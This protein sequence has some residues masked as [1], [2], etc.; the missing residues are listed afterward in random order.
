M[1]RPVGASS[2]TAHTPTADFLVEQPTEVGPGLPLYPHAV[3]FLPGASDEPI[4]Q[5]PHAHLQTTTYYTDDTRGL[6]ESW[7]LQHLSPE[8]VRYKDGDPQVPEE[9]NEMTVP[10]DSIVFVGKRGNQVR[11]AT[12][13]T[14]SA[15]TK[16]TLL[17]FT[18]NQSK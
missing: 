12:L 10:D 1:S 17:R 18:K 13:T 14:N 9:L 16:I 2:L 8:F 15:G 7:Y 6:V 4:L 11:M 5:K 3:L